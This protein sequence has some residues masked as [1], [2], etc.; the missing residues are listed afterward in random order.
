MTRACARL[1]ASA[2]TVVVGG[3]RGRKLH[4]K[5]TSNRD[6]QVHRYTHSLPHC[7]PRPGASLSLHGTE[8]FP[9]YWWKTG[10]P[11]LYANRTIV[12]TI[13]SVKSCVYFTYYV[14]VDL[15]TREDRKGIGLD[16]SVRGNNLRES[17]RIFHLF[18]F[19]VRYRYRYFV[20]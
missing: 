19:L 7:S 6:G 15:V 11:T 3:A 14:C 9:R 17:D 1:Y 8:S 12:C 20:R 4:I 18:F 5:V 16:W 10:M 13:G 2:N